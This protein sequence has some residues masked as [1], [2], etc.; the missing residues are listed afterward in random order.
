MIDANYLPLIWSGCLA[1]STGCA[2][3][4][5]TEDGGNA[6]ADSG[7]VLCDA[8]ASDCVGGLYYSDCGGSAEPVLVCSPSDGFCRW[9]SGG[10]PVG[11]TVSECPPDDICCQETA[12]GHWPFAEWTGTGM[13][14]EEAAS[15]LAAMGVTPVTSLEPAGIAVILDSSIGTPTR[16]GASCSPGTPLEICE[17]PFLV[18]RTPRLIGESLVIR[19]MSRGL[20]AEAVLLEVVP[21]EGGPN[22]RAFVRNEP[23]AARPDTPVTCPALEDR[24]AGLVGTLRLSSL[25][26]SV[27]DAVHGALVAT[28]GEHSIELE[29]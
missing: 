23:D 9:Y 16:P 10:C 27:P 17:E 12:D 18:S 1:L 13:A 3:L 20:R 14:T 11:A 2:E 21:L 25:D 29:F 4:V 22:A 8:V 5:P 28:L 7:R 19:L 6:T 15:H 24:L 26:W